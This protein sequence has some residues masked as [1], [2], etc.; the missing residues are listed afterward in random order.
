MFLTVNMIIKYINTEELYRVLW[1]NYSN[2][3]TYLIR[4]DK[5]TC[6]PVLRKV[7]EIIY[8]IDNYYI[9]VIEDISINVINEDEIPEK[10]K[11]MRDK[12][13]N[14]IQYI[15]KEPDIFDFSKRSK[16]ILQGSKEF[17][18]SERVIYKY[19][20]RYW[21]GGMC[22][23]T[24]IPKFQNCGGRGKDKRSSLTKMG[25]PV[26]YGEDVGINVDENIKKIF[27]IAVQKYYYNNKSNP[28]TTT[29]EL[30]KK[31][32]F[33][34]DFKIENGI[35]IPVLKESKYIPT[36]GQFRY[37]FNIE[38]NIQKEISS[39]KSIKKY[40]LQN[41]QILGEST[42]EAYGPGSIYQIDATVGD[43]YLV[44]RYNRDWIIGRPII[45]AVIDVFSRMIVG[46]YVGLEGPSW[47]GAMMAL[48]NSA[49]DKVK[50][51]KEYDID[52]SEEEWPVHYLPDSIVADRGEFEGKIAEGLINGLHIKVKNT[53]SFR[54]DWKGIVEQYFRTINLKIK[55]F[56]PGFINEDFRERGGKDYR[57][58]AKLDLKQF[59]KII[60]KCAIFHNNYHFLKNYNRDEM[61]IEDGID[62]IPIKLWGWGI[63]NRSGM[64]R[65]Y[66]E[67]IVK[68]NIMPTD[69]ATVTAKGIKFKGMYYSCELAIKERWFETARN[70]GSW[71]VIIC[72]DS[73]NMDSIYIKDEGNRN[74]ER[75]FLLEYQEKFKD[76]T[77]EEIN[78]L[79]YMEKLNEK[80]LENETSQSKV[81]LMC[82]IEAI[83]N[84]ANSL[85]NDENKKSKRSRLNGIKLNRN[86]EK[87]INRDNEAFN[88]GSKKTFENSKVLSI[89]KSE[90]RN[91]D[92]PCN[93]LLNIDLFLKKQK[94]KLDG[95]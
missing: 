11:V 80:K 31:E 4:I 20:L 9:K 2:T 22:K 40:Q 3:Y 82:D 14:V 58:D 54:A 68:L 43:V 59:T 27:N 62:C 24:L 67:D 28:I 15:Y 61:M 84:E 1:I 19:L 78:H 52:I 70:N 91:D 74:Y 36:L 32:F 76:R 37:W 57:L 55:P 88:L 73:R 65:S 69:S 41:R 21:K 79:Y 10:Y 75:C 49:M 64:L 13:W 16:L 89:N 42:T 83:V 45:Y 81:D 86:L 33:V 29:Y 44:S 77:L 63:K 7:E 66:S 56:I 17:N 51:C 34:E 35:K 72:F 25:R 60:I 8:E 26:I 85:K 18:L 23:N 38:R 53:P 47:V 39:R 87:E 48:V 90:I 12:S 46:V 94:E 71:R 92:Y 50:F 93:E 30:M 6:K 95:R 5:D